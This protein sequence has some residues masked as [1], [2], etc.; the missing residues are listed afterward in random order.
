MTAKGRILVVED[1]ADSRVALVDLLESYNYDCAVASD[2][3]KALA[4]LAEFNPDLILSDLRMPGLDGIGLLKKAREL[5]PDSTIVLMTGDGQVETAVTA[6]RQGAAD[7][8]Q[9][10]INFDYLQLVI[11]RELER[12]RLRR[13]ALQLRTQLSTERNALDGIIGSSGAAM[14][15]LCDTIRMVA[16]S[17]ASVIISGESGTGKELIAAAIH[18]L[19]PRRLK[20]FVKLH[21]ASLSESLLE[22]E[23]FGHEKG[24][25]TGA[26]GQRRGRFEQA[27]GG[28][29]FL[30]EI[31]EISPAVQV[32]LLRVLQAHEIER[33]GSNQ[34]VKIDARIVAATNR[35]LLKEVREGRF[36]EDL[37]YRLNVVALTTP[38]LRTMRADIPAL[39]MHFLRRFAEE[40]GKTLTGFSDDALV[41]LSR[42]TWPGNVRELENA[43]ERAVL[44]CRTEQID[45]ENFALNDH[46]QSSSGAALTSAKTPMPTIPGAKMADIERFAVL[47]TLEFTGGST[48]K[49]AEILGIS[50]RKIQYRLQEYMAEPSPLM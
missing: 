10:P 20:P 42:H 27:D 7:Y 35:D 32:K 15:D 44:V 31:G 1:N 36:R 28:T 18:D 26:L 50:P 38:P 11:E 33:V 29:L 34:T 13:E 48:A 49:A 4:K 2:G 16:P 30:D 5:D 12:R 24:A 22:S 45:V 39:A 3:F 43:I 37:F 17:R 9:K 41:L 40:N 19:S 6:M 46:A 8:V 47:R 25:F 14:R 23:L 21:C